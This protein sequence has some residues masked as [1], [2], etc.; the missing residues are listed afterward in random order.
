[1]IAVIS[2]GWT[3]TFLMFLSGSFSF[4]YRSFNRKISLKQQ[5]ASPI[6]SPVIEFRNAKECDLPRISDLCVNEFEGP[7]GFFDGIRKNAA[8]DDYLKEFQKRYTDLVLEKRKHAMIIGVINNEVVCFCEVG[9]L[10]SP[11]V[12]FVKS[13]WNGEETQVRQENSYIEVPYIGNVVVSDQFRRKGYGSKLIRISMKIAE[14]WSE[15]SLFVAVAVDNINAQAMYQKLGFV[16]VLDERDLINRTS[17][18]VPRLF[19]SKSIETSSHSP[20]IN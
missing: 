16:L 6:S 4:Q 8:L 1:M 11:K 7:F 19:F 9:M 2:V 10:P 13:S 5:N 3:L 20:K 15:D 17:K 14:K 12:V 18:K